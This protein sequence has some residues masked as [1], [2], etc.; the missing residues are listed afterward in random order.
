MQIKIQRRSFL[1]TGEA[2]SG[3]SSYKIK[4]H[5]GPQ[6]SFNPHRG[7]VQQ[8][9]PRQGVKSSKKETMCR[10]PLKKKRMVE[11]LCGGRVAGDKD[12]SR[13]FEVRGGRRIDRE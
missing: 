5:E 6:K 3:P 10:N 11:Y 12:R 8:K 4:G 1:K 2:T 7:Q 9:K 13:S